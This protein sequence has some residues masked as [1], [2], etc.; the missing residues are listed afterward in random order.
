MMLVVT[1]WGYSQQSYQMTLQ[2]AVDF[3]MENN[4][5]ILSSEKDIEAAKKKITETTA[6]GLPQINGSL[7]YTDNVMLPTWIIPDFSDPTKTTELKFGTKYDATAAASISQLI[8]SGEYIVGLQASKKYLQ[9]TNTTFFK[10]K[11][12][13][14]KLVSNSYY[15]ALSAV[16]GLRIVDSTLTVTRK[17]A[18]ETRKVFEVGL[19][20]DIDVDQLDLL[21]ADLEASGLY[22]KNQ[23]IIANA[24]LKFYLG[25]NDNDSIILVDHME[26]LIDKRQKSNIITNPFNIKQNTDYISLDQQKEI[27]WLQVKLAKSAYMPQLSANLNYQTQAQREEWNFLLSGK[28]WYQSSI[29]NVSMSIP[30]FSSGQRWAKVK[31]AQIEYDKLNIAQQKLTT[32]LKLQYESAKNEYINAYMVYQNKEKNRKIAEKI[33]RKTTKKYIEGMATSMDILNTHNQFLDTENQYINSALSVLQK[34]EELEKIL[35]KY[36]E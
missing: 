17:L 24:F 7:T 9:Q 1:L 15:A 20:E 14:K 29:F 19:A 13:V 3:A 26:G 28:P 12:E 21:V 34:G 8:F 11:I 18:D 2:Q 32:Q 5:D 30:I 35:T 6:I 23:I 27:G 10:S 25:V 33:Y 31:Q 36:M 4:Y 16:E 22:L